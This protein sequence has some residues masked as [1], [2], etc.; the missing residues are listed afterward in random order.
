MERFPLFATFKRDLFCG[1]FFVIFNYLFICIFSNGMCFCHNRI[2]K[3]SILILTD[4]ISREN[5]ANI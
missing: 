5:N 1:A 3:N 4:K 2:D